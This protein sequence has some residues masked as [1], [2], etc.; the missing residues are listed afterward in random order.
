MEVKETT[1][2]IKLF[3]GK[4]RVIPKKTGKKQLLRDNCRKIYISTTHQM[5]KIMVRNR[6]VPPFRHPVIQNTEH[7]VIR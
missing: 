6:K 7:E 1:K 5:N 2:I 4:G 3:L